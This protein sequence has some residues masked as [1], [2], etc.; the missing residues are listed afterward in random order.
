MSFRKDRSKT[1]DLANTDAVKGISK[2]IARLRG[3]YMS[4]FPAKR[5]MIFGRPKRKTP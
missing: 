5:G 4:E 3:K 1:G 2:D